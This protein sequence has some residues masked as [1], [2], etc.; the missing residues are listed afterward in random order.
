MRIHQVDVAAP[1]QPPVRLA[2]RDWAGSANPTFLLVHGLASN[3]R[4]WDAVARRLA[5]AGHRAVAVDLRS[6]GDSDAP[7]EGYD[8]TTAADDL[9]AVCRALG[10]DPVIAVG[11]SW[12]GNVVARFAARHPHGVVA[13]GLIDGGWLDLPAAFGSWERCVEVLRP[14]DVDGQPAERLRRDIAA[15][16]PDWSPDAVEATLA[17]LRVRA[18]GT[19]QRRLAVAN[20]LR[21][22][23]SMWD[24]PPWPD[25]AAIPVPALLT[26]ALPALLTP[27]LPAPLT[28]ALPAGRDAAQLDDKRE[29][30]ARAAA[31]LGHATVR[32]YP[33]GD[34]D[35]HAQQPDR[36]AADLIDLATLVPIAAHDKGRSDA[37]TAGHHGVGRDLT[38]DDKST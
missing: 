6:H 10:L 15:A 14:P 18:D 36:I 26:P 33:G 28:P 4:L 12:G 7:P 5:E 23:R 29:S 32:A 9:A 37:G 22:L 38:D 17:N 13:I 27:A 25:L 30:V 11:Q 1:G 20:H 2:L 21:I 8:T 19:V 16:H 34:H 3:A 31:A 35:L 24:S